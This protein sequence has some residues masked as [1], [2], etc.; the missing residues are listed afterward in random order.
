ME[1]VSRVTRL[2]NTLSKT[3][4]F[5]K[6]CEIAMQSLVLDEARSSID[7]AI[8][9]CP[10]KNTRATCQPHYR[11]HTDHWKRSLIAL[12]G[13]GVNTRFSDYIADLCEAK[14]NRCTRNCFEHFKKRFKTLVGVLLPRKYRPSGE[15]TL[16]L[17][18]KCLPCGFIRVLS[19]NWFC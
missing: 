16:Q 10:N 12:P 3:L 13:H 7:V 18:F 9:H 19:W 1:H 2:W 17:W 6:Y 11:H 15:N 14:R 5:H 8:N 4:S